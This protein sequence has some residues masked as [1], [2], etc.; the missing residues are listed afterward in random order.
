MPVSA[1]KLQ[2]VRALVHRAAKA[3][4][5]MSAIEVR[6]MTAAAQA[7]QQ[8][9]RNLM[10]AAR[11]GTFTAEYYRQYSDVLQR[12]MQ[13]LGIQIQGMGASAI[14]THGQAGVELVKSNLGLWEIGFTP[15]LSPELVQAST[16]MTAELV[17]GMTAELSSKLQFTLHRA[18]LAK[19]P[20]MDVIN[21]IAGTLEGK[22]SVFGSVETRAEAIYRT[23]YSRVFSAA[24]HRGY[25][26]FYQA[27]PA[28]KPKKTWIATR[29]N[30]TREAHRIAAEQPPV[31][32]DEPFTVWGEKLMFPLDPA[33]SAKN[34]VLCR[35][36]SGLVF[37]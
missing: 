17:S 31:P 28:K 24:T 1:R 29:D 23:E 9:V 32:F 25:G 15:V 10:L 6:R 12:R 26:D 37:D 8:E 20:M 30:R 4:E 7:A 22:P 11:P 14:P 2:Q 33:G 13:E 5:A 36:A 18:L 16:A 35:C 21:E 3:D 34:T 27:Y 19:T